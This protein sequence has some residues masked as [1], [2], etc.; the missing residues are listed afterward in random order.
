MTNNENIN[1]LVADFVNICTT[2][3]S[4]EDVGLFI[5]DLCETLDETDVTF[6]DFLIALEKD[7]NEQTFIPPESD[8]ESNTNGRSE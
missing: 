8:G 4:D 6:N 5:R 7:N 3:L 2:Y 1:E